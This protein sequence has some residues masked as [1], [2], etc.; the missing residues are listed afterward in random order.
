MSIPHTIIV[1]GDF[2][3]WTVE[4]LAEFALLAERAG[5]VALVLPDTIAP[6]TGGEAW[7]D[8]LILIGWLAAG[9]TRIRLLARVSSL[10]HQPY[11]LARR[12]ASLELVSHGRTG[13]V[14][15]AE[16]SGDAYA[17]FSGEARL[18]D[19]DIAARQREFERVVDGLLQSWD[20]DALTLDRDK[21]QFFRPE[22]MH[23]LDHEGDYFTVRGPL[24]VMR[25]PR[26]KPDVLRDGDLTEASVVT[27]LEAARALI[28]GQAR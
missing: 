5:T 3:D 16:E 21:G 28:E 8:A 11:N 19:A 25:S 7:P 9:T 23:A 14:I 26:G 1:A 6:A 2:A 18:K 4:G 10:G 27:S 13:W 20:A 22:A 17:A 24:N 12:L 15:D